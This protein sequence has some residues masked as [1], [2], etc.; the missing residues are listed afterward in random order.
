M[1]DSDELMRRYFS[2]HSE[3]RMSG[4]DSKI[5]VSS[6]LTSRLIEVIGSRRFLELADHV[7]QQLVQR[8]DVAR[9]GREL[10]DPLVGDLVQFCAVVRQP[11]PDGRLDF[12][13]DDQLAIHLT[14]LA[15]DLVGLQAG[16]PGALLFA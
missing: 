6:F 3:G 8:G 5:A 10:V 11:L 16:G 12:A 4:G 14:E 15:L 1:A 7:A 9:R 2:A 13:G